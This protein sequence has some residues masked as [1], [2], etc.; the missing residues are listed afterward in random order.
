MGRSG[1]AQHHSSSRLLL[2]LAVLCTC[3]GACS[4]A[5]SKKTAA[6]AAFF[7]NFG[8]GWTARW[9]YAAAKKYQGRFTVVKPPGFQDTAIQVGGMS[10]H[11]CKQEQQQG[12][13]TAKVLVHSSR[14]CQQSRT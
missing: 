6:K 2:V 13:Q 9:H 12:G 1:T 14:S 4:A 5:S 10:H 11:S 3:L 7:E 8:P